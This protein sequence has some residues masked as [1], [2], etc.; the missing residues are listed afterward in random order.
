[1]KEPPKN[2]EL[3][4]GIEEYIITLPEFYT[5]ERVKDII[6]SMGHEVKLQ[7]WEGWKIFSTNVGSSKH[8]VNLEWEYEKQNVGYKKNSNNESFQEL[9]NAKMAFSIGVHIQRDHEACELF[10]NFLKKLQKKCIRVSLNI[11]DYDGCL[12]YEGEIQGIR[13]GRF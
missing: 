1:M 4:L 8:Y 13:C 10:I 7:N 11:P 9:Y 2:Y 3:S 6:Q 5:A 12:A